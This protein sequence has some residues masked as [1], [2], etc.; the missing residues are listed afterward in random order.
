MGGDLASAVRVHQ[1]GDAAGAA[2]LYEA[3]LAQA[4]E[5]PTLRNFLGM[6]QVHLQRFAEGEHNLR[7]ALQAEPGYAEAWNS[8]GNLYRLTGR[9]EEALTAYLEMTRLAPSAVNGWINLA[10][11]YR[12]MG[13]PVRAQE[14]LDTAAQR[15]ADQTGHTA[16]FRGR[17]L[18]GLATL[19][20]GWQQWDAAARLLAL[21]LDCVPEE[22]TWRRQWIEMLQRAGRGDEALRAAQ[23]WMAR[24]PA[25]DSARHVLASVSG[26]DMP[27]RASDAEVKAL[28]DSHARSFDEQLAE[29]G[30]RAPALLQTVVAARLGAA[31]SGL[32]VCDAGCGTGLCGPWLREHAQWLEGVDLSQ[33]MLDIA[34]ER[35]LYDRLH[36]AELT[37]WLQ[38]Q[39]ERFDLLVGADVLCYF[40]DL[41]AVLQAAHGALRS[42]GWLAFTVEL[43]SEPG[44]LGYRL[45]INGR[46]AH[47]AASLRAALQSAGFTA[48]QVAQA[49]L[50]LEGG[51][52]VAGLVVS[53]QR[54]G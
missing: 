43:A 10:D 24:E 17:L 39:A 33:G 34:Q 48:L 47:G 3:L 52:P 50:R 13:A 54:T 9:P 11:L 37:A 44:P 23:E 1:A 8:L 6:A 19:Q 41:G 16:A 20:R 4:P 12:Q 7:L 35:G 49:D 51:V 18:Q 46:Y 15:A 29:L 25:S 45:Q 27:A 42:G 14:A 26:A 36:R 38:A 32:A 30:Y 5:D 53:A 40:G 21:A 22:T 31:H 28:F 2:A